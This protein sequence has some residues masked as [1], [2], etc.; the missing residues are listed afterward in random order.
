MRRWLCRLQSGWKQKAVRAEKFIKRD[1]FISQGP[2]RR[3][4]TR[5]E[6]TPHRRLRSP[7]RSTGGLVCRQ[8][9]VPDLRV[10]LGFPSPAAEH[11]VMPNANLKVMA[12]H[13]GA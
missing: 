5:R 6:E 7:E 13:M 8:D 11:A 4:V 9:R 10:D 12:L 3:I 1:Y 2:A